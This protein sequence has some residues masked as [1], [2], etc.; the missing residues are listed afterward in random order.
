ME[1]QEPDIVIAGYARLFGNLLEEN[2]LHE[3]RQIGD[4]PENQWAAIFI[5]DRKDDGTRTKWT[6]FTADYRY[7]EMLAMEA[8]RIELDVEIIRERFPAFQR[9]WVINEA[10]E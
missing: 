7:A 10:A 9:G 6:L 1:N 3:L 4:S 5:Y 8:G 2:L